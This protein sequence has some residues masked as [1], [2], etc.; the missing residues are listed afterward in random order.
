LAGLA[1]DFDSVEDDFEGPGFLGMGDDKRFGGRGKALHARRRLKV[2]DAFADL[3]V[4]QPK[5]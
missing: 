3:V 2:D 5:M 1:A 4:R